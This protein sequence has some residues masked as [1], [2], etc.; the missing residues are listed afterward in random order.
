LESLLIHVRALPIFLFEPAP[1]RQTNGSSPRR[2]KARKLRDGFAEDY[3]EDPF[4]WRNRK[5]RG[6][7][8]SILK[9]SE[10][11]RMS[12]ELARITDERAPSPTED[13]TGT[14]SRCTPPWRT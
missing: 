8:P 13:R 4:E 9:A 3:F 2:A 11:N 7:R 1:H 5:V 10:F 12:R 6:N 14:R